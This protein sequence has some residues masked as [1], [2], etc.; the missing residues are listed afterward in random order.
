MYQPT[1]QITGTRPTYRPLNSLCYEASET[2]ADLA[3]SMRALAEN[4]EH[5]GFLGV[6]HLLDLPA[7]EAGGLADS[8]EAI[9]EAWSE[10]EQ[11]V[12][13]EGGSNA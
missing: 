7:D 6:A 9:P 11:Q 5:N 3:L 12:K 2:A 1:A 4:L 10:D 13:S 8:I